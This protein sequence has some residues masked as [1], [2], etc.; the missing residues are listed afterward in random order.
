MIIIKN[1][2]IENNIDKVYNFSNY[3]YIECTKYAF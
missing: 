1:Y 2:K 3:T